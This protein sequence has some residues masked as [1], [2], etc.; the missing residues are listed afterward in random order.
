MAETIYELRFRFNTAEE[1]GAAVDTLTPSLIESGIN[2][3]SPSAEYVAVEG[4]K[5]RELTESEEAT[6]SAAE[7]A[8]EGLLGGMPVKE[9]DEEAG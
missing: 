2:F 7:G 5:A 3:A 4:G 6:I 8:P 9:S 1:M